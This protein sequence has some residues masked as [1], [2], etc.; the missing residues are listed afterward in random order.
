MN[1]QV[2]QEYDFVNHT[3]HYNNYDIEVI[4]MIERIWGPFI[5]SKWCEITAFKYRQRLGLKPDN[6]IQ[7]DL[8]KES[9]YLEWY[10]ELRNKWENGDVKFNSLTGE[11]QRYIN[12][13]TTKDSKPSIDKQLITD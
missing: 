1:D 10:K 11:E 6:E 9:V 5:A 3:P 12:M 7:Q 8:N 13:F 4:E 2:K